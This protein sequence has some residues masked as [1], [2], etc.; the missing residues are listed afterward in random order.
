VARQNVAARWARARASG[1]GSSSHWGLGA[2]VPRV[3]DL[4]ANQQTDAVTPMCW[5]APRRE[6]RR[7]DGV[8]GGTSSVAALQ[9]QHL[10]PSGR[11]GRAMSTPVD[12][13]CS[14]GS[15]TC[16]VLRG[17]GISGCWG[18]GNLP[19]AGAIVVTAVLGYLPRKNHGKVS[20]VNRSWWAEHRGELWG[21]SSA[22]LNRREP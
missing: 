12:S 3:A 19:P 9:L 4:R 7:G 13:G 21:N 18:K 22:H 14:T 1:S 15:K 17:V 6:R 20:V 10:G 16:L 2:I 8:T 5:L 11:R